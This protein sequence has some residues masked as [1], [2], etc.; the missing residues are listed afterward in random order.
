MQYYSIRT[1]LVHVYLSSRS[2]VVNFPCPVSKLNLKYENFHVR[3]HLRIFY[4]D[5][6]VIYFGVNGSLRISE[7]S[8]DEATVTMNI[9]GL[10]GKLS[11]DLQGSMSSSLWT[12][13]RGHQHYSSQYVTRRA[14]MK[15]MFWANSSLAC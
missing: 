12:L 14:S 10:R 3:L 9:R 2:F 13:I 8:G 1:T 7:D 4:S 11:G 6:R 5:L 15:L